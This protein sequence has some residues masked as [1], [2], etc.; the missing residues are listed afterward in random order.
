[1]SKFEGIVIDAD[2]LIFE[3]TET[4]DNK[5]NYFVNEE[6][7]ID[8]GYKK[9]LKPFLIKFEAKVE[10]I[11]NE[12]FASRPGE[13]TKEVAVKICFSDPNGNFRYNLFP[14]YKACRSADTR[15]KEFFRLRKKLL[16]KY[17][18]TKGFE[19]DDIVAHYV[20][21]WGY[22][23][24]SMDKDLWK[25]VPGTWFNTH[26][27]H[28]HTFYTNP[29][30]AKNWELIQTL[31]GDA[32]DGIIGIKGIGEIK[33]AK[34]LDKYGWD[35]EGVIKGY[36]EHGRSRYD[37]ILNRRLIGMDQYNG[38]LNLFFI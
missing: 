4:R 21:D 37:A 28:R 19:A 33:A 32:G 27:M 22:L 10:E 7:Y 20:R 2:S 14:E 13:F 35:F 5:A 1:M 25:G 12:I 29:E 16:K 3:C 9:P 36:D 15:S 8:E 30:E 17:G 24:A 38:D 18:Y 6:G 34:L 23:G 31:T 11:K 26:F